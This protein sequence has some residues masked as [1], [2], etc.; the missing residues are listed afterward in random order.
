MKREEAARIPEEVSSKVG[1]KPG[2]WTSWKSR[3]AF[4]KRGGGSTVSGLLKGQARQR[5]ERALALGRERP[6]ATF[7]SS[8]RGVRRGIV[9]SS[10]RTENLNDL[11]KKKKKQERKGKEHSAWH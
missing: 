2:N 5:Q 9:L 6:W 4:A 3:E 11:K 7:T 1:G 8:F 10:K